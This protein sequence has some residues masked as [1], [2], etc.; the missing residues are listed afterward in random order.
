MWRLR[1]T[2]LALIVLGVTSGCGSTI[3]DP[4]TVTDECGE[5]LC[6]NQKGTP[7]GYCSKA[8]TLTE[9]DSCPSGSLCVQ[10]GAGSGIHACF[11][12]CGSASDCRRGYRCERVRDQQG[13]VCI[14]PEGL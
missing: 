3:G 12:E 11:L 6:L 4:C 8:C 7:G 2:T 14:G 9:E 1:Q 5:Q 13:T 10:D